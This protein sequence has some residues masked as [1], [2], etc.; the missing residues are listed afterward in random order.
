[1]RA[2]ERGKTI[3]TTVKE[4][5]GKISQLPG[6]YHRKKME[7]LLSLLTS[8]YD[9]ETNLTIH[10]LKIQIFCDVFVFILT[11]RFENQYYT[12]VYSKCFYSKSN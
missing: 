2:G 4:N 11:I 5:N 7:H 8:K 10:Y 6:K 12:G 9:K 3:N 1:M